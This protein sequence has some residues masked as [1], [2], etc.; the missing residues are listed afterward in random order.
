VRQYDDDDCSPASC[1]GFFLT[2]EHIHLSSES[3]PF[4]L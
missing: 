4:T 1:P 3:P 2:T